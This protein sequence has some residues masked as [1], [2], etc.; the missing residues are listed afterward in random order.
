MA[1]GDGNNSGGNIINS[2][3]DVLNS[4]QKKGQV[5]DEKDALDPT[6]LQEMLK[7]YKEMEK[8]SKN[9]LDIEKDKGDV[10][11][12]YTKTEKKIVEAREEILDINEAIGKAEKQVILS[13]G[14]GDKNF[15]TYV[16]NLKSLKATKQKM[17]AE[18]KDALQK[19][20]IM[21]KEYGKKLKTQNKDLK[22]SVDIELKGEKKK[23]ELRKTTDKV[24]GKINQITGANIAQ[25]TTLTGIFKMIFNFFNDSVSMGAKLKQISALTVQDMVDGTSAFTDYKNSMAGGMKAQA[26]MLLLS[27]D[28]GISLDSVKKS[29]ADIMS[30]QKKMSTG[31]LKEQV[32]LIQ[33]QALAWNE[34][35]DAVLKYR[36]I[37]MKQ[38]GGSQKTFNKLMTKTLNDFSKFQKDLKV[39]THRSKDYLNIILDISTAMKHYGLSTNT[40]RQMTKRFM[41]TY[42]EA[43]H[44]FEQAAA[45]SKKAMTHFSGGGS[46]QKWAQ[47][48]EGRRMAKEL[49]GTRGILKLRNAGRDKEAKAMAV[50]QV[51]SSDAY[52]GMS[53]TELK[54]KNLLGEINRIASTMV[55]AAG[56]GQYSQSMALSDAAKGSRA[57]IMLKTETFEQMRRAGGREAIG[58][59]KA[60]VAQGFDHA[61]IAHLMNE[62]RKSEGNKE[63]FLKVVEGIKKEQAKKK[64]EDASKPHM[65]LTNFTFNKANKDM[66]K[67][68]SREAG[69]IIA[70]LKGKIFDALSNI[71][72]HLANIKKYGPWIL[73]AVVA[74][75]AASAVGGIAGGIAGGRK[76]GG[77][78]GAVQGSLLLGTW[79]RTFPAVSSAADDFAASILG[80][81]RSL[82]RWNK[83]L[84]KS[85][86]NIH[87]VMGKVGSKEREKAEGDLRLMQALVNKKLEGK[88]KTVENVSA[89]QADVFKKMNQGI[90]PLQQAIQL[91]IRQ[92]DIDQTKADI[93]GSDTNVRLVKGMRNQKG[94][95]EYFK[96]VGQ[97]KISAKDVS[98]K[99]ILKF[100]KEE[101]TGSSTSYREKYNIAKAVGKNSREAIE[102]MYEKRKGKGR[103]GFLIGASSN[104]T[105]EEK[106]QHMKAIQ[107]TPEYKRDLAEKQKGRPAP[108][109]VDEISKLT[110]SQNNGKFSVE[111]TSKEVWNGMGAAISS[112]LVA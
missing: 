111:K 36:K 5:I 3:Q 65:G 104:R 54:S 1:D 97:G 35:S 85:I 61:E 45:R 19:L 25:F 88:E 23:L 64:T 52:K 30:Y 7:M 10:Q 79:L 2:M 63:T 22:E 29:Y 82:E 26:D 59:L 106:K 95:D 50:Q 105:P 33:Y 53:D 37:V 12:E 9:I 21:Q 90:K 41:T 51:K 102:K 39:T 18:E 107:N 15:K 16:K 66:L 91:G 99:D 20:I 31:K 13:R 110:I 46:E 14:K 4:A 75:K 38:L 43:G 42:M 89:A 24:T 83:S 27:T 100:L 67:G 44:T 60:T 68:M 34:T 32:E 47:F 70:I 92:V 72:D 49:G 109:K 93:G 84:D 96:Q 69:G 112:F 101:V 87:G 6:A 8:V 58:T 108:A 86:K 74:L 73:A 55:H 94:R 81:D 80:A 103:N 78:G 28:M 57:K 76:G 62:L 56:Q 71:Q 98:T 77:V 48:T 40:A 17:A 11:K